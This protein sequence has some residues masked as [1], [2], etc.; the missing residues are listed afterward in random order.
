M[1][2]IGSTA[3]FD[4]KPV[5][6]PSTHPGSAY[7]VRY[8]DYGHTW[9]SAGEGDWVSQFS[10]RISANRPAG[11][12]TGSMIHRFRGPFP[13]ESRCGIEQRRG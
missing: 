6:I 10:A 9:E 4:S 11:G 7:S 8:A 5:P 2:Q 1:A 12:V 3:V 13:V